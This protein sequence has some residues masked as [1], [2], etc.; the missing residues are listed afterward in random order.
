MPH[1]AIALAVACALAAP[2]CAAAGELHL[3]PAALSVIGQDT[4]IFRAQ[5]VSGGAT[6]R[7]AYLWDDYALSPGFEHRTDL[8]LHGLLLPSLT[9]DAAISRGPF[10]QGRQ[11]MTFTFEGDDA[12]VKAGDLAVAFE[13]NGLTAFRRNL[14]GLLVDTKLSRGALSLIASESKP[15]VRTDVLYGRNSSGPYYL[16]ATPVVDA[17]EVVEVDGRRLRRGADYSVDYQVGLIQFSPTLIIPPTSRIAVSYEYDSPGSSSGTLVG[18][19]ASW[20][21]TSAVSVGATYLG[22]ERRGVAAA[23]PATREDR[24]LGTGTVGP[25][26]L[27]YRPIEPGS[28]RVRLDGILQVAG[29]DYQLDY[30]T[31]SIFFLSPVPAGV[32]IVVSYQVSGAS[33]SAPPARSLVGID[34]HY[35]AG[36]HL[37]LDAEIAHS[38]GGVA[39]GAASGDDSLL[40]S[41]GTALAFGARGEWNRLS[42]AANL[43][44][45]DAAFA[46]FESAGQTQLRGGWDWTLGFQP[47]AG[48]RLSAAMRDYRRPYFQ[49]ASTTGA[50][51][52]LVHDRS[53]DL[54]LD[55]S[56]PGWPTLSYSGSWSS[57]AGSSGFGERSGNQMLTLGFERPAYGIKATYRRSADARDGE[58]PLSSDVAPTYDLM[59]GT[60]L[61]TFASQYSGRGQGTSIS[62][63]YR[64]GQR[65]SV[66]CDLA[67]NGV[68]LAG[69]G[70][71]AAGSSRL[72]IEYQPGRDTFIAFGYRAS[73]SGASVSVDGREISG[74]ANRSRTVNIRHSF[75]SGLSLNLGYDAQL[76]E[77][78]YGTNS[79]SDAWTGGFS[80]QPAKSLCLIG[81][82]TRQNLA[83]LGASGRSAN[84]IA[85]LGATVGP[86]GPG[87]KLDLSYSHMSGATSGSFGGDYGQYAGGYGDADYS[88][89]RGMA[90]S[91]L[92]ARLT[93]PIGNRQ[94]A[95]AEWE[96]SSNSGYPGGNRRT[97]IGV[98]WQIGLTPGLNFL[99]DWRRIASQS[100]DAR[101]SYHAQA[102]SGSLGLKF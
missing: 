39:T 36:P 59:N 84:D 18:M 79:D 56:R 51:D 29:K 87:L 35:A 90:N 11:H 78:G 17:S 37:N 98:G 99:V 38:V 95:F 75:G 55:F 93:Y 15:A 57:L 62:M 24:W 92:R 32:F 63:Y 3:G 46:P 64:P 34:T 60:L 81:Q 19:R 96:G 44:S 27:T 9:V 31:G 40:R 71:S 23:T 48:L 50:V 74:Y 83:Y 102:L 43:R 73:S 65:L 4:I 82:Y 41:S 100:S 86:V 45:A 5:S 2:F 8:V 66:V 26:T 77:G 54:T 7:S 16:A 89:A 33:Q 67:R 58:A 80:W 53:H 76:S 72:G 21:V 28:E 25:F 1:I 22:L 10:S 88:A 47:V 61:S 14:R 20:P 101:F 68:S 69:G 12:V 97:S 52:L 13:G 94:Q 6:G 42:L 85:S 91:G 49:Y 30:A 70:K